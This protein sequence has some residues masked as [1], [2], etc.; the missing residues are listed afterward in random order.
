M[1]TRSLQISGVLFENSTTKNNYKGFNMTQSFENRLDRFMGYLMG[2]RIAI[3]R[4]LENG[5]Q[6]GAGDC[7]HFLDS[8]HQLVIQLVNRHYQFCGTGMENSAVRG[9]INFAELKALSIKSKEKKAAMDAANPI[10]Q[11]V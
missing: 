9:E 11:A 8:T 4:E 5:A 1:P 7:T 6:M 3:K 2:S 10:K